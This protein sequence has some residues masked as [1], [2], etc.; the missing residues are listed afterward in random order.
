MLLAILFFVIVL[1]LFFLTKIGI[2]MLRFLEKLDAAD[3]F[4]KAVIYFIAFQ[5]SGKEKVV[6]TYQKNYKIEFCNNLEAATEFEKFIS[7]TLTYY[8]KNMK[9]LARYDKRLLN[10]KDHLIGIL[11]DIRSAHNEMAIHG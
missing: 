11:E 4:Y 2:P 9:W 6:I 8:E 10:D 3:K 5:F 1:V 7:Q